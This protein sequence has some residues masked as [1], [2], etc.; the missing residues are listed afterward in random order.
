MKKL[1]LIIFST[2]FSSVCFAQSATY[3]AL[4]ALSYNETN[5][6]FNIKTKLTEEDFSSKKNLIWNN[7]YFRYAKGNIDNPETSMKFSVVNEQSYQIYCNIAESISISINKENTDK[8]MEISAT[9]FSLE[10]G[11][12]ITTKLKGKN[13]VIVK[14]PTLI[15]LS[16]DKETIKPGSFLKVNFET[17]TSNL[18]KLGPYNF[19]KPTAGNYDMIMSASIPRPFSY[20]NPEA[21][22]LKDQATTKMRLKQFTNSTPPISDYDVD[23][24]SYKWSINDQN[25]KELNFTLESVYFGLNVGQSAKFI[26]ADK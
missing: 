8:I 11:K 20:K 7:F 16:I 1:T 5:N 12:I 3:K 21:I 15:K 18:K 17:E 25:I 4:L 22:I 14:E 24:F 10:N 23:S 19:N 9:L 13:L 26:L 2:L 6:N